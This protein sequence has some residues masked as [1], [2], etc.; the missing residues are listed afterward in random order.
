MILKSFPIGL[1]VGSPQEA[2]N[3]TPKYYWSCSTYRSVAER[4]VL[5]NW[6][7]MGVFGSSVSGV[8]EKANCDYVS[9]GYGIFWKMKLHQ[10]LSKCS[11]GGMR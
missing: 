5:S 4:F 7:N 11:F 3:P 6:H 9:F 2:L 8:Y 10:K 1:V